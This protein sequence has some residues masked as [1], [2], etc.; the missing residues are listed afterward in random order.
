MNSLYVADFETT[1][2][3]DDCRVWG[4]GLYN[5]YNDKFNYGTTI[6]DFFNKIF[7]IPNN[8]TLYF[9]NLKFDGE[10]IFYY[11]YRRGFTHTKSRKLKDGEFT[12]LISYMGAFYSITIKYEGVEYTIYDSLKIIPLPVK[13]ISK[14]F[15]I[16]QLK[17]E[18][19]Y[20]KSRPIG[21]AI[22]TDEVAYI[23]NDVEIVGKALLYFFSQKL[24][25]MTQASN[26]FHDFKKIV[27]PKVFDKLFPN[28]IEIDNELRQ[29]YKGGYAYVNPPFQNRELESGIVFDVNSLYPAVMYN[30]K[31][32]F[33]EPVFYHGKYTPDKIYTIYIQMFKCNFELKDGYL[34]T[35]QIKHHKNFN[36]T[37]YLTSSDGEDVT[38]YLTNVDL[39]MFFEHYN[40][41]NIEWIHGW[42]FKASDKLFRDYI[43]KWIKIKEQ[44]TIDGNEGLRTLAKLM[45][46]SLYGKFGLNPMIKSKFPTFDGEYIRY[47]TTEQEERDP[48]YIPVAAFVTSY[49]RQITITAAQK[50][51]HRF[52]YAD[53]DSLHLL[54]EEIPDNI[55]IDNVK[56]GYWKNEGKFNKAK[57]LRAKSYIENMYINVDEFNKLKPEKQKDWKYN[58]KLNV[59]ESLHV[60]CAGLPKDCHVKINFESFH[61]GLAIPGK[62]EHKRVKGGVVLIEK[63]FTIK[64]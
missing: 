20:T 60:A 51:I 46:N 6:D 63:D 54:G 14:A 48:I 57:F 21:Y 27:T 64:L 58:D 4:W 28:L 29:S 15:G 52:A 3:A 33:G 37:E 44:A 61:D 39:E 36:D 9:H 31:L 10:F 45:L 25:K 47:Q 23:K 38:L 8:T 30:C 11:L 35:L 42:K 12:S 32:P 40:V 55:P 5:I 18:I 49:A 13:K 34:P 62:L 19:D 17:G 24:N 41:Y 1:T 2:K 59:Y 56:L 26:A 22:Q 50:N 16:S 7:S 43:D 53:T